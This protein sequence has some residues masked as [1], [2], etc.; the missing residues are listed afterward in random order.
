ME[1][2]LRVVRVA[3]G[4]LGEL[5]TLAL[6]ALFQGGVL[7]VQHRLP[8]ALRVHDTKEGLQLLVALGVELEGGDFLGGGVLARMPLGLLVEEGGPLGLAWVGKAFAA[9]P[10]YLLKVPA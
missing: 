3:L 5:G 10:R 1:G 2:N 9:A 4:A 6:V 7:G 8:M